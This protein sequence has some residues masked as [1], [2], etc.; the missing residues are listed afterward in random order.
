MR[1]LKGLSPHVILI[2]D[3]DVAGKK[4]AIRNSPLFPKEDNSLDE[5][6]SIVN[7]HSLKELVKQSISV[8]I[9]LLPEGYDPDSFIC[10]V[11]KEG[12][13]K[14]LAQARPLIDWYL[15]SGEK[16]TNTD[17]EKRWGFLQEAANLIF[18]FKNPLKKR[19]YMDRLCQLFHVEPALIQSLCK[20]S[21]PTSFN[22]DSLSAFLDSLTPEEKRQLKIIRYLFHYP[23]M[24]PEFRREDSFKEFIHLIQNVLLN[25]LLNLMF[26]I[27]ERKN[28]LDFSDLLSNTKENLIKS[29]ISRWVIEP[30]PFKLEDRYEILKSIRQMRLKKELKR[31]LTQIKEAEESK[32]FPRLY[33]L[34]KKKQRLIK[35]AE[36]VKGG[37][38][39]E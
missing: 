29:L 23:Q 6:P 35:E 20:G 8:D 32:D 36:I 13:L 30:L 38:V 4:A 14:F 11:G 27:Y 7:E 1:I 22:G 9:V 5:S 2:Y 18:Q 31:N 10:E 24:I 21:R 33:E 28:R 39:Y 26:E 3:A 37:T 25:Q 17:F 19:Y 34:L 15:E 12:F 16:E